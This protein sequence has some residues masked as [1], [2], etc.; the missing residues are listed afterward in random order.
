VPCCSF[1]ACFVVL[2][3]DSIARCVCFRSNSPVV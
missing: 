1:C 2:E 3:F